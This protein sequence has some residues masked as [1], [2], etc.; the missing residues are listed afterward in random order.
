MCQLPSVVQMFVDPQHDRQRF[1]WR[2]RRRWRH[3]RYCRVGRLPGI[4][5]C[6]VRSRWLAGLCRSLRWGDGRFD[7]WWIGHSLAA[8]RG[9]DRR[10]LIDGLD[11]LNVGFRTGLPAVLSHSWLA[12]SLCELGEFDEAMQHA[13]AGLSIAEDVNQP[14]SIATACLATGQVRLVQGGPTAAMPPSLVSVTPCRSA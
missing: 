2:R 10:R 11:P 13:K 14:Y 12:W 3:R 7:R 9:N 4:C 1:V 5:L 6:Q 8:W